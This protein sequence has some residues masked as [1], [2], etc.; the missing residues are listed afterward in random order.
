MTD[1]AVRIKEFRVALMFLTRLPSRTLDAPVPTLS[2][3]KWAYPLVGVPIGFLVWFAHVVLLAIGASDSI[4]AVIVLGVLAM[5]TGALHFDGLADFAD[6]IGG[7]RDTQH[8]LE[9][10]RDSRIGSYG[11]LALV[12]ACALWIS[13]V[14]DLGAQ[15]NLWVFVAISVT[16]RFAM[17]SLLQALPAARSEGLGSVA[18][19]GQSSAFVFGAILSLVL[20]L[21]MGFAGVI[22]LIV[23]SMVTCFVGWRALKRIGGQTGDVLGAA[24][25]M[26]EV[27]G[28]TTIA[29]L[30]S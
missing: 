1:V 15:A 18:G 27:A 4:A 26:S 3:C 12:I 2:E 7:G 24:Q 13:A 8:C 5:L 6:G 23:M 21:A 19:S 28:L 17:V 29:I 10:M 14:T 30:L 25:L 22:A 9:I 20:M 16:S 11:V